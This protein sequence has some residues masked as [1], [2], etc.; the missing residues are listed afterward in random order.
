MPVGRVLHRLLHRLQRL[1]LPAQTGDFIL[2]AGGLGLGEVA[3]VAVGPV[4]GRQVARD[5]GVDL[6]DPLGDLGH[7]EV[8]VAV[9][10]RLELAAVDRDDRPRE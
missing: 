3:L 2:D 9:V 6:L 8:L 4:Q 5:A 10:H 7:R 1:H